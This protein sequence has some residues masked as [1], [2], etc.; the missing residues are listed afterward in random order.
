MTY[1]TYDF[2][3]A[4]LLSALPIILWMLVSI[5][6]L[7]DSERM[8]D[9]AWARAGESKN[10]WNVIAILLAWPF[11]LIYYVFIV[12]RKVAKISRAIN[13]EAFITKA[14]DRIRSEQAAYAAATSSA[15]AYSEHQTFEEDARADYTD[16]V[17]AETDRSNDESVFN[18]E[19]SKENDEIRESD[20]TTTDVE[21]D[22]FDSEEKTA[23]HPV[24]PPK[25][26]REPRVGKD[27]TEAK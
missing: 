24:I 27:G 15:P 20:S 25:P 11:G 26:T 17:A 12:R 4:A 18:Y 23:V 3:T 6:V 16:N 13:E 9:E 10:V 21:K 5:Y 14:A 7:L 22:R 8:S 19:E 1:Y 2:F